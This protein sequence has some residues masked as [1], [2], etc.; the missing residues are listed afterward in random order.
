VNTR[1]ERFP[2]IDSLRAIAALSVLAF[3]A[4]FFAGMYTSDSP[5]RPYVAQPIAGVTLFFVISGFLLYRPFVRARAAEEPAPSTGAYAWRRFLRIVPAYWLALTVIT[6]WLSLDGVFDPAWHVPVFYGFAQ[7]YVHPLELEGLGQAWTLCVEVS[8][9]AFLPLWALAMRRIGA[10]AEIVA[11]AGLWIASL[12]WKIVATR[13]LDAGNAGQWL[14]PLPN[15][16]DQF[17]VGMALAIVSVHGLPARLQPAL[18][19]AWPWWVLAAVAYWAMSTRIGLEGVLEERAGRSEFILRHEL[20][21]VVA[22]ALLVP[23]VFSWQ[24]G[25]AVRRVLG[26]RPLLF[27][28]LVSYG[29]YL[30]H[31]AVVNRVARATA[32]WMTDT[33]GLGVEA[34]FIVIF[35]LAGAG[36]TAIATASFYALERPL[37]RLKRRAGPPSE[38]APA[39]TLGRG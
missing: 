20:G 23:T 35:T 6:L 24:Q 28:G 37:L 36:A 1:S 30:W 8:F 3:H 9:Y 29:V 38:P 39:T 11:L 34:R 4:A 33:L 15:F 14:M 10:R 17:A 31:L 2:L 21:T 32:D 18:R 12:A 16:L 7:I 22:A 26:W 19:R 25:G 27:V 5:L 13:H